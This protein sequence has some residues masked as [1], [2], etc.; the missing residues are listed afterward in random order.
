MKNNQE[1][2]QFNIVLNKLKKKIMI[3]RN[4]K[5]NNN[6]IISLNK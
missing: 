6:L 4:N 3:Y 2:I 5:M 1:I